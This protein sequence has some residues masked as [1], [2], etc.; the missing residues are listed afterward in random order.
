MT[1]VN[2]LDMASCGT[3]IELNIYRDIDRSQSDFAESITQVNG[4]NVFT[5]N[6]NFE[7]KEYEKSFNV[8]CT[9]QELV[10]KFF[11]FY[12]EMHYSLASEDDLEDL[13]NHLGI[14]IDEST[15][16]QTI[17]DAIYNNRSTEDYVN[18]M[19]EHFDSKHFEVTAIGY[20]Q[21]DHRTVIIPHELL[22]E[23]G[24][25]LTQEVA[26]GF[27][28]EINHLFWDAPI[29]A[30]LTVDGED[31]HLDQNLDDCYDYEKEH[32]IKAANVMF[33]GEDNQE[34]IIEFLEENLPNTIEYS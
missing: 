32:I 1:T 4:M 25:E 22:T 24:L 30:T 8:N 21:G 28:E 13:Q 14:D 2:N 17:H 3:I 23:L 19:A 15:T 16:L 5:S 27:K 34:L 31:F 29:T 6:G 33:D 10:E 20:C 9:A 7:A 11:L 26:D 12:A 18:F